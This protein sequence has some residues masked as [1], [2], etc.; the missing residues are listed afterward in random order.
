MAISSAVGFTLTIASSR[1]AMSAHTTAWE[2]LVRHA[3]ED[4]INYAP[5]PFFALLDATNTSDVSVAF[6]WQGDLLTGMWPLRAAHTPRL[7]VKQLSTY[8]D[9]SHM[10][11]S[12]PLLRSGYESGSIEALLAWVHRES[13][14]ALFSFHEVTGKSA[15]AEMI[16]D[17]AQRMGF[18]CER[19]AQ[20]ERAVL[21]KT[22]QP[23][24]DY[25]TEHTSSKRRNAIKRKRKKLAAHGHWHIRCYGPECLQQ[26][27]PIA[28]FELCA[29]WQPLLSDLVA[30]EAK[31]WKADHGSAIA[32]NPEVHHYIA[33]L[34]EYAARTD[35]LYLIAAYLD[36]TPVAAQLGL[37]NDQ[38]IMI[39]KLG[40]DESY[41][42]QSPGLLL[43]YD[44]VSQI[45]QGNTP[46]GIDSCGDPSV[47]LYAETLHHRRRLWKTRY[48]IPRWRARAVHAGLR[49]ARSCAH[50]ARQLKNHRGADDHA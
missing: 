10:M 26:S 8:Y 44:M 41:K 34:C 6:I 46:M 45:M 48:G 17:T 24:A 11:S 2:E 38:D 39:Y 9:S 32:C 28:D 15:I 13:G 33:Q 3:A 42:A 14:A 35:Q 29:D 47:R 36:D 27:P 40:F 30:V 18:S 12:V 1:D 43:T 7:P 16:D 49:V 21:N 50:T 25:Y 19:F 23:F 22:T 20:S 5:E 4:N 31:S 37:I